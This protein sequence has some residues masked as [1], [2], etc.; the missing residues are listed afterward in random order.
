[1][2]APCLGA[3]IKHFKFLFYLAVVI[4]V[5]VFIRHFIFRFTLVILRSSFLVKMLF[6]FTRLKFLDILLHNFLQ[7]L[8]FAL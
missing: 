2:G 5:V 8:V 4:Q 7:Y 1:M 6:R 3:G